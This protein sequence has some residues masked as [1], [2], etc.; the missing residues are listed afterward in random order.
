M[1][2][3]ALLFARAKVTTFDNAVGRACIK[4]AKTAK[5]NYGQANGF[6]SHSL[7][8]TFIT[9]LMIQTGGDAGTVMAYSGHRSLES[10]SNY[11]HPSEKG[12][13]LAIQALE[14]VALF[15]RCYEGR[16]GQEGVQGQA[17]E[18][19]NPLQNQEIAV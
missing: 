18:T 9:D 15:L 19:A 2:D 4:A 11:L 7:R 8:H 14:N 6:T 17:T 12:C 10:F 3:G 1:T 13:K 5:L 16:E